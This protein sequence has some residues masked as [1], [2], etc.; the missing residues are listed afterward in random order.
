MMTFGP[1]EWRE[2][3]FMEAKLHVA[4]ASLALHAARATQGYDSDTGQWVGDAAA[5]EQY[6]EYDVD[7]DT[8]RVRRRDGT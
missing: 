1:D 7:T 3:H 4:L 2:Q 6:A 5:A 8:F